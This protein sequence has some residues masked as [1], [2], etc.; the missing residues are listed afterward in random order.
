MWRWVDSGA[1][2][3][4]PLGTYHSSL[5]LSGIGAVVL[6]LFCSYFLLDRGDEHWLVLGL[7]LQG[8]Y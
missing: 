6:S 8:S 2:V 1:S 5:L 3:T 7:G 4:V